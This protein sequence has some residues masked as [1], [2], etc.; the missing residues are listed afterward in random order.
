MMSLVPVGSPDRIVT[1]GPV[2][3][4]SGDIINVNSLTYELKTEVSPH[5]PSLHYNYFTSA[6]ATPI[7]CVFVL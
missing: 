4:G 2:D 3:I 7:N 1:W 5:T 6:I